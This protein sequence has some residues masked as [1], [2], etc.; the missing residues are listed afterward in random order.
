MNRCLLFLIFASYLTPII[1]NAQQFYT[2]P[3]ELIG[4]HNGTSECMSLQK[5][6]TQDVLIL[7]DPSLSSYY[8]AGI[9]ADFQNTFIAT[10]EFEKRMAQYCMGNVMQNYL[11]NSRMNLYQADS[12]AVLGFQHIIEDA[13]KQL[14]QT[15]RDWEKSIWTAQIKF[16]KELKVQFQVF[17]KQHLL[18]PFC[19]PYSRIVWE[20]ENKLSTYL[21]TLNIDQKDIARLSIFIHERLFWLNQ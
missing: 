11:D 10:P 3:I 1:T 16:Y 19:I 14:M 15:T 5:M 18:K 7:N 2:V 13:E 9:I 17:E 12:M 6:C 20:N 4:V 21:N 8:V